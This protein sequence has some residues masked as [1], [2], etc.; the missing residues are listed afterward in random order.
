MLLSPTIIVESFSLLK[1]LV[2][3]TNVGYGMR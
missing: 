3:F 2:D 1:Y